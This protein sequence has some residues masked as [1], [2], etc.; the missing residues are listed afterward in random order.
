M[1][2]VN[3]FRLGASALLWGSS[4][5]WIKYALHGFSPL[6]IAVIRIAMGAVLLVGVLYWQGVRLPTDRATWLH[7]LVTGL[8][9]NAIPFVLFGVGEQT[10]DSSIAGIANA[11]T[12]LWAVVLGF[13]VGT[14]K[15]L[16]GRKVGGIVLGFLGTVVV[17]APWNA[18]GPAIGGTLA[19]LGAAFSYAVQLTYLGRFLHN[20]GLP[21][22]LLSS[23]QLIAATGWLALA[24]PVAGTTAVTPRFDAFL[25]LGILGLF[26]TG[27]A[28]LL[29]FPLIAEVG[30]TLASTVTYLMP[31][32]AVALGAAVLGEPLHPSLVVG[33]AIV[34]VGIG[35]T[36]SKP[37]AA[38]P[39]VPVAA[40]R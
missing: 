6:Q 7:L 27:L 28:F 3:Y 39:E 29:F 13:L 33:T 22:V 18:G 8:F 37:A 34:L 14:E 35:L 32:V 19:C 24:V 30:P 17:L 20:Q 11:T 5:L 9:G 16:T 40:G 2:R 1:N 31:I 4:F 26:G 15:A 25:A 21:P 36:R 23:G 12:P 10:V 38:E